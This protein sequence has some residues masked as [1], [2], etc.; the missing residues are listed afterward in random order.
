V[1][2]TDRFLA[3]VALAT[4]IIVIPGPSVLFVL[5]RALA[6]GRRTALLSVLGNTL[7]SLLLVGGIA[8]G[9]GPLLAGSAVALTVL[10]L[11]GAAYLV[12]LGIKAYRHRG[13]LVAAFQAV[14]PA[15]RSTAPRSDLRTLAEGLL[16]GVSNPKTL[17]FY[18]AVLPQ[19]VVRGH[20]AAPLPLQLLFLGLVFN[21][22]AL[23]CDSCWGLAS[24][25]AR[26]WFARSPRGLR[27]VGGAG[28]LAMIGL[29]VIVAATGRT[30]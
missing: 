24:S 4:V 17:V 3:F 20:G 14:A 30:D 15:E 27:A 2:P 22:I 28:G 18:A 19:F 26:D 1:P 29:G 23:T 8:A 16:V 5:G 25:A 9:L 21:V 10:K 12:H 7:G 6:H 11:C 13:S